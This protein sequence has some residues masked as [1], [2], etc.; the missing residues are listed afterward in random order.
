[1]TTF[2]KKIVGGF[3]NFSSL[4]PRS[5]WV[6]AAWLASAVVACSSDDTSAANGGA[7][8]GGTA[9]A[10]GS[11]G[12]RAGSGGAGGAVTR[13][14]A[15]ADGASTGLDASAGSGGNGGNGGTGGS[16]VVDASN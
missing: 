11:A 6:M 1:M 5:S 10:G 9:G 13:P 7:P 4:A 15:Q 2:T 8:T 3:M 12:A 16:D 14:D